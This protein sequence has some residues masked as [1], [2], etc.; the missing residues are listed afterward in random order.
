[1]LPLSE[2]NPCGAGANN[3]LNGEFSAFAGEIF[4]S[5]DGGRSWE[6]RIEAVTGDVE[7]LLATPT[8]LWIAGS[9]V[10]ETLGE[11]KIRGGDDGGM[12]LGSP[13]PIA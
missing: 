9:H 12:G 4:V 6:K 7:W 13:S 8:R 2:L 1:M 3:D 5:R 10:Q 11:A